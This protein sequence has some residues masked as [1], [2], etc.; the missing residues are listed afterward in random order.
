[1]RLRGLGVVAAYNNDHYRPILPFVCKTERIRQKR[2]SHYWGI[3]MSCTHALIKYIR[4]SGTVIAVFLA[5]LYG[6]Q[7]SVVQCGQS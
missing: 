1:M 7:G 6:R 2:S 5:L 3:P 4:G